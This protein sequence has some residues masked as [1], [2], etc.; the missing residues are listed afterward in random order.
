MTVSFHL[1]PERGAV[2]GN[3]PQEGIDRESIW[4]CG[5]ERR[6][7]CVYIWSV[8][9]GYVPSFLKPSHGGQD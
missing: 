6:G 2:S 3:I 5:G 4:N 9:T 1:C 8:V 7:K